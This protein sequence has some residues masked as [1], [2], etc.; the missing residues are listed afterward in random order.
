MCGEREKS[1]ADRRP[2]AVRHEGN[3]GSTGEPWKLEAPVPN[4]KPK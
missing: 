4:V 2:M 1:P 3:P